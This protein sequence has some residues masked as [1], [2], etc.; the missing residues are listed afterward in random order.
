MSQDAEALAIR[1][2][3]PIDSNALIP[4]SKSITNRALPMAFLAE[5][6]SEL[7]GCLWSDDTQVMCDAL[8]SLGAEVEID[9]GDFRVRGHGPNF[10]PASE[11]LYVK[12]SGTSARFLTALVTLGAGPVTIDGNERMRERP[13]SH[14]RDALEGLGARLDILG[15]NT[16]A[17]GDDR[18]PAGKSINSHQSE[19][20]VKPF[21]RPNQKF[22]A[23]D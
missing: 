15:Q 18:N 4:G 19:R 2:R 1:P 16:D 22:R 14:L 11:P 10:A 23:F 20:L 5:G 12:N 3:G 21:R 13:I 17:R 7:S 6:Q 8:R 9:R